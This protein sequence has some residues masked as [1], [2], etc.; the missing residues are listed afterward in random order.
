MLVTPPNMEQPQVK[1]ITLK[2]QDVT[3]AASSNLS[4]AESQ[5]LEELLTEHGDIFCYEE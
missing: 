5:E 1:D 2:S 4:D 3:A